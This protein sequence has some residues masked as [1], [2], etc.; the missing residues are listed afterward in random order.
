MRLGPEK[1]PAGAPVVRE[2]KIALL[3]VRPS[4]LDASLKGDCLGHISRPHSEIS[5]AIDHAENSDSSSR[6]KA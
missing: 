2:V 6:C 1:V 5:S 3:G 4:S